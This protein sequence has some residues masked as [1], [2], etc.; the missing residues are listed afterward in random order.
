MTSILNAAVLQK[1][2]GTHEDEGML[3]KV[4]FYGRTLLDR[5]F[6]VEEKTRHT[7]SL[8]YINECIRETVTEKEKEE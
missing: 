7:T 1:P 3:N 5:K 6:K 4:F 2:R 8:Q